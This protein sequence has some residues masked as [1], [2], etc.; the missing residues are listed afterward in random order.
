MTK[1]IFPT[2]EDLKPYIPGRPAQ[3]AWGVLI[4]V[5]AAVYFIPMGE[6]AFSPAGLMVNRWWNEPEYGHGFFVPVFALVLLWIR[7]D[8]VTPLPSIGS[9]RDRDSSY[10]LALAASVALFLLTALIRMTAAYFQFLLFDPLSMLTLFA[11]LALFVGGWKAIRWAYPS[12]LFLV[13]MIPLPGFLSGMLSRPLQAIGTRV[14]LFLI[15]T[16]GIPASGE[17]NVIQLTKEQ[18]GVVEACS[19]L[20]MLMLFFAICIGAALVMRISLWEKAVVVLSA[21]PIAIIAN[22]TRI[23]LTAI[24]YEMASAES[25]WVSKETADKI[26]HDFAGL[27]MMPIALLLLWGEMALMQ[28]LFLDPTAQSGRSLSGSLVSTVPASQLGMPTKRRRRR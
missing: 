18:L 6:E 28:R 14:S 2:A 9:W 12:V 11:G 5:F 19:G 22:V 8:M 10:L 27:L 25:A 24:L 13:F 17:G 4:A 16:L 1:S 7:R 20:R 23:T 21:M 15:Q 3:I 26:F